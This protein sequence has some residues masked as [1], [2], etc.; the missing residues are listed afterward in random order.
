MESSPAPAQTIEVS[1]EPRPN[2]AVA[3]A[4]GIAAAVIG[5]IA[6]A[7]I[8]VTT[9]FQI[10]YMAI[11]VGFLVGFAVRL[12]HGRD[13]IFGFTGAILALVGCLMGNFLSMIGFA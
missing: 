11:G 9:E 13:K 7:V 5:G 12:G 4:A 1:P 3:L 2:Y 8:T 6:W 10:G